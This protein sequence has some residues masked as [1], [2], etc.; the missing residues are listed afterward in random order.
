MEQKLI[1]VGDKTYKCKI[2]KSEEDKK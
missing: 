1:N 2:A